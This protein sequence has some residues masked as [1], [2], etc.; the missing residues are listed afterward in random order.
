MSASS[1]VGVEESS[2][3]V[4]G[5]DSCGDISQIS[6]EGGLG[7]SE[8]GGLVETSCGSGGKAFSDELGGVNSSL[9]GEVVG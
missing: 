7:T 9:V 6:V 1:G 3:G 2:E 8:G 4:V 5:V